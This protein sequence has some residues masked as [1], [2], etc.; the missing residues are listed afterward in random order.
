VLVLYLH[1]AWWMA[2]MVLVSWLVFVAFMKV[3]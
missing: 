3:E 1:A 2:L